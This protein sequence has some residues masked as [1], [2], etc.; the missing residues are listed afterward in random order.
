MRWL[1]SPVDDA[2][3]RQ[4]SASVPDGW[5]WPSACR[6]RA[7]AGEADRGELHAAH[8]YERNQNITL[9]RPCRLRILILMRYRSGVE[10][11]SAL[12]SAA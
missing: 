3:V 11:Y 6:R 1:A 8:E 2:P 7:Y 12:C 9:R 4:E 5:R 10:G